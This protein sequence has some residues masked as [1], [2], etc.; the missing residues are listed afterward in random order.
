MWEDPT[1][2]PAPGELDLPVHR[3]LSGLPLGLL[4]SP[5]PR[6][7]A[8]LATGGATAELP[9]VPRRLPIG[10]TP[11]GDDSFTEVAQQQLADAYVTM[12]W[13]ATGTG[14]D[15]GISIDSTTS[16]TST[17]EDALRSASALSGRQD[18]YM[19]GYMEVTGTL[20][21]RLESDVALIADAELG[22]RESNISHTP[23]TDG[24]AAASRVAGLD[25]RGEVGASGGAAA[26]QCPVY[27]L[28]P[29]VVVEPD[30]VVAHQPTLNAE[31][32]VG[33]FVPRPP[34]L[35]LSPSIPPPVAPRPPRRQS[36]PSDLLQDTVDNFPCGDPHG[37][38]LADRAR[39]PCCAVPIWPFDCIKGCQ[40]H[41]GCLYSLVCCGH[42]YL[43]YHDVIVLSG[44]ED[45]VPCPDWAY[46]LSV[47]CC[48]TLLPQLASC[49]HCIGYSEVCLD[50]PGC[51]LPDC[52]PDVLREWHRCIVSRMCFRGCR[53][54]RGRR[55]ARLVNT[56]DRA[57]ARDWSI[58]NPLTVRTL[59]GDCTSVTDWG[60]AL[61]LNTH[62]AGQHPKTFPDPFRFKLQLAD[63]IAGGLLASK[64]DP[65]MI[66]SP[67]RERLLLGVLAGEAMVGEN[68]YKN[69]L[70]LQGCVPE[71]V[72]VFV[73]MD[74]A[75]HPRG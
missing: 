67:A 71:V 48:P 17:I 41:C 68:A 31:S 53:E 49:T 26:S 3:S 64:L 22:R 54:S 74:A 47:L 16:T 2:P 57:M 8:L 13:P 69:R 18:G 37:L 38:E 25:G 23:T 7:A 42:A 65:R 61:D 75:A 29:Q 44:D 32:N 60:L 28:R 12:S 35:P 1:S 62:I 36:C 21:G 50:D 4:P 14:I 27:W 10:R 58:V 15:S 52:C 24:T 46:C 40:L 11:G 55:M 19:D 43:V 6:H 72:A 56:K 45:A 73:E 33:G 39:A 20:A 51:S 66:A 34:S 30:A 63:S 9:K 70:L 59:N 5:R